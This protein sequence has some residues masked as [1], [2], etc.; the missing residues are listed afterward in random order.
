MP[1]PSLPDW[2]NPELT[3]IHKE[4]GHAALMPFADYNAAL[5]AARVGGSLTAFSSPFYQSLNGEWAFSVAPNPASA[6]EGFEQP[7]FDDSAWDRLSVPGCWQLQGDYDPPI[8]CNVQY[9]FPV[10]DALSVPVDD[11]PTGSYRRTFTVPPSWQGREIFITFEGVDSAFHLWLNGQFV[12]FSKDSKTPAEFNVTRYLQPGENV[13]AARVYRWSDGSY[14]EDQ[15]F[16]RLS[17]IY[18][19]V[20]LWSA[21][22]VHLRDFF[23]TTEFDSGSW[24]ATLRVQA[25][26]K[27]YGAVSSN[28]TL[29]LTLFDPLEDSEIAVQSVPFNIQPGGEVTLDLAQPV[30]A[31][32]RWTDETPHLYQLVLAV[33]DSAGQALEYISANVG[34]RKIE[35]IRGRFHLNGVSILFKGV[36]RHE[37]DEHTG[38]TVTVE[39]MVRDIELMKRFN[40]NAVRTCHYPNDPR[41][42]D[43][44]DRYG[45]LLIDEANVETHGVWD[46][47]AKEPR[48]RDA[49]VDRAARMVE[50]DKN[51]PSVVTWSLGNESGYGPNHDAMA[52]WVRARDKTRPIHYE[53]A[54]DA[55][56]VDIIST[57]YPRVDHLIEA[58]TKPGETRPFVMCEYAHSMGNSTGN[59][60]EYW[61]AIRAHPRLIGGFIWD[62][63]DQGLARETDGQPWYAYGGD[64]GDVPN[65]GPFCINGLIWPDR[66]VHPALWEY[67]K[68]LEPVVVDALDLPAGRLRVTNRYHFIDLSGLDIAWRVVVDGE[69]LESGSLPPLAARPG[70]S[71]EARVPYAKAAVPPG[72]EAWLELS[73][74]LNEKFGGEWAR[75]GHEVA[76][77]QFDLTPVMRIANA[78]LADGAA[79]WSLPA[80]L[81][82]ASVAAVPTGV[83]TAAKGNALEITGA[84]FSLAFDTATGRLTSYQVRGRE[85][86]E[87]GPAFNIWRALTDNDLNTWGEEKMGMRWREAGLDRLEERLESVDFSQPDP[88]TVQ[89][90]VKSVAAPR[91]NTKGELS[92]RF[93]GVQEELISL[94]NAH[95]PEENLA[96]IAGRLGVDYDGLPAHGKMGK[97][98][99]LVSTIAERRAIPALSGILYEMMQ[100]RAQQSPGQVP[101]AMLEQ[102]RRESQMTGDAWHDQF[103][104]RYNTRFDL[105]TTYTIAASGEVRL[106]LDVVPTGDLPPLPRLGWLMTL[107]EGFERFTWYGPGPHESYPDRKDSA[108]VGVYS[109]TVEEQHVPYIR[110][111]ENGNHVETRWAALT[112]SDGSGRA[113]TGLAI[114]GQPLFSISAHHYTPQTLDAANHRHEIKTHPGVTLTI[115]YAVGG[116]GNGSCGPG[117]LDKYLLFPQPVHFEVVL[118]PL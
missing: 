98:R 112:A 68:V 93:G 117:T 77:T 40:I 69:A 85:L 62:W 92:P 11:N 12:G 100:Q 99:A 6:P 30:D 111:Q 75:P 55:A 14:L 114:I 44:C 64:F 116:L 33:K 7:A 67:K 66:E 106:A 38:H 103:V 58:A 52:E 73:F 29:D 20:Y 19:D 90:V 41:W 4:P 46:Q 61:D 97:I 48:W 105:T 18:R 65:D 15:D 49:F 3:G 79:A 39:S 101:N 88:H 80:A 59:L 23:V 109:T 104:L 31:P 16:W 26:L 118:R 21:P 95:L 32:R 94:L 72:K 47:P 51:H 74:T 2:A 96:G 54:K 5:T 35:L 45:I 115:D 24:D 10:D 113:I 91:P 34:F 60:K 42:Y 102:F 78:A 53:S 50:R 9:P 76:W 8:Y 87:S 107:S 17:G 37:F 70:E 89:V 25:S 110:P 84:G 71:A 56:M 108:R 22:A 43:L 28:Y 82:S 27:A 57:M 86:V 63:V 83:E 81:Q 36:N 1:N 13:L